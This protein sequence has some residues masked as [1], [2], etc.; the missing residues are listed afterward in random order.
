VIYRRRDKVLDGA[1]LA[2]EVR[3]M[4][5]EAVDHSISTYCPGDYTEEWDSDGLR[6]DL[7]TYWPTKLTVEQ[8][9]GAGSSD[10]LYD[11]VMTDA[12]AHAEEREAEF[13]PESMR[14]IERQI[15]LRIIDTR[16]RE[17]LRDMDYLQDGIGLRAMG[18]KDPLTEWQREGYDMFTQLIDSVN[19]EFVKYVMHAQVVVDDQPEAAR[20]VQYSAPEDPSE[21]SS[22]IAAAAASGGEVAAAPEAVQQQPVVKNEM[23]KTPRNAPCPCGSGKKYKQCHGA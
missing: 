22:A 23:D 19:D 2:D 20:N 17:H 16:W 11:L 21:A 7:G 4:L 10:A 15:M 13:G 18:Q 3:Q 6:T 5:A 12:I 1:D 8:I 14:E 9:A